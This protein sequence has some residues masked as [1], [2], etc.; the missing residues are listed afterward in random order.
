[1]SRRSIRAAAPLLLALSLACEGEPRDFLGGGDPNLPPGQNQSARLA[2]RIGDIGEDQIADLAV[3]ASGAVYVTGTFTGSV[4]FD[5][6]TGL[7]VLTSL[8]GNDV[9]V[10]RYSATNAL[11]WAVQL[12]GSGEEA[13]RA[14]TLDASGDVV[15]A[16]WFEGT[17][18]FDGGAGSATLISAGG[19][20]GFVAKI[21][22]AGAFA[23][24]R[25]FGGPDADELVE[26]ATSGSVVYAAGFFEGAADGLPDGTGPVAAPGL[27]EDLVAL[28]FAGDGAPLGA[29][30]LGGAGD[31]R[32]SGITAAGTSFVISGTFA[33]DLDF[34][35]GPGLGALQPVGIRDGF[36]AAFTA[37]GALQWVRTV[38]GTGEVAVAENGLSFG[39]GSLQL[40]GT[41]TETVDLDSGPG[42]I[43][44]QS[45]G[46]EDVFVLRVDPSGSLADA[47]TIGSTGSEIPLRAVADGSALVLAG[48][49]TTPLDV[50]P[51]TG[52]SLVTPLGTGGAT[53]AFVVR[54]SSTGQVTWARGF[55]S[56]TDA[57]TGVSPLGLGLGPA[58]Q[59]IVGGR[60]FGTMDVDPSSAS[61]ALT[62]LG[63]AD[64]FVVRLTS[65]G[66]LATAP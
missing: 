25:R 18:D 3:D 1:M 13:S 37:A 35:P 44:A 10:A 65:N 17:P 12:G 14:L 11:V 38:G 41:F 58:G 39:G 22:N 64:G 62:S 2:F 45:Q 59:V 26:V 47:F 53:E 54:Y 36:L 16:G 27:G 8:G 30:A 52:S 31:E 63:G 9:F 51:G 40:I 57:G 48:T 61:F 46:L 19:R 50:D 4:D 55:G 20:D 42:T 21:S 15:V 28:S 24:V 7:R 49:F 5:P 23:W 60:F 56:V 6:G 32:A 34:D 43:G 33:D 29:V 66:A